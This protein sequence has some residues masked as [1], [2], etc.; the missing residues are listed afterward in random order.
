MS[1]SLKELKKNVV[2]NGYCIGCGVCS[3]FQKDNIKMKL[4]EFGAYQP[5][6]DGNDL[7]LPDI[8]P[9]YSQTSET[10]LGKKFFSNNPEIKYHNKIGYYLSTYAGYVKEDKYRELG[11]SGGFGSWFIS[12]L[13][14]EKLIDAAIHVKYS[15]K[16]NVLFEYTVSSSIKSM[17]EG[18]KSKYYPVELSHVLKYVKENQGNYAFVGVPCFV[19]ALRLACNNDMVLNNRIKYFIGLFC[20]HLKTK[21]FAEMLAWQKG[22]HPENLKSIDFRKKLSNEPASSYGIEIIG[23]KDNKYEKIIDKNKNFFGYNWG[24][25]FFK[26]KACDY[27]DDVVNET[28]DISI[29]DAWLPE[30][31]NDSLGTNI[32]IV[33]SPEIHSLIEK[34]IKNG[35]LKLDRITA[36]K[37]I[38]SQ[39]GG[40][41]HRRDILSYRLAILEKKGKWY[42][43]KRVKPSTTIIN[44]RYKKIAE[45]RLQI[46]DLSHTSF[47]KALEKDDYNTFEKEM[48]PLLVK[49]TKLYKKSLVSRI[50]R[51]FKRIIKRIR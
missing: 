4:N 48:K 41:R 36:E 24:Y 2:D 42:P 14:E 43:T 50:L 6:F 32:I 15:N 16:E 51:K 1:T 7:E 46:T 11:S 33:R 23:K 34:G 26:Y 28:A 9:F 29:G 31:V 20:G 47:L 37:V 17:K 45:L 38:K 40:F 12:R 8:C 27:C 13:F 19:K 25:G 49:Y 5:E 30:Y 44:E 22:I 3:Y 10:L 39:E 35:N 18:A 21:R